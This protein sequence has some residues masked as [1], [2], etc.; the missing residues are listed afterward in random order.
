MNDDREWV[1]K[2]E[3]TFKNAAK[4][5]KDD[6]SRKVANQIKSG[7]YWGKKMALLSEGMTLCDSTG[8]K[9]DNMQPELQE[10]NSKPIIIGGDVEALYPSMNHIPTS[11]ILYNAMMDTTVKFEDL[12]YEMMSIYL[13]L[14]LGREGMIK[15]GLQTIPQRKEKADSSSRS[16]LSKVNREKIIGILMKKNLQ[17][18]KR[19][20]CWPLQ[21]RLKLLYLC[22]QVATHLGERFTNNWQAPELG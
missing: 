19:E 22:Q 21:F 14:V 7:N 5:A 3:E 6:I 15:H 13:F 4:C 9:I 11:K 17:L 8:A 18:K 1:G 16:L 10:F 2:M 20:L 12:D